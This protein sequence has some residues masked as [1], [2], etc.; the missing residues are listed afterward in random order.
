MEEGMK[1]DVRGGTREPEYLFSR[2]PRP[3]DPAPDFWR[4]LS[5]EQRRTIFSRELENRAKT[6][7]F[8][9]GTIKIMQNMLKKR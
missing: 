5:D 1:E 3:I 2:I 4:F 7:E 8:D 9:L 6:L